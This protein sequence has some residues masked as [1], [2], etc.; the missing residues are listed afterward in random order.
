M[1]SIDVLEVVVERSGVRGSVLYYEGCY[2][3][4]KEMVESIWGKKALFS[5]KNELKGEKVLLTYNPLSSLGDK[6]PAADVII[7]DVDGDNVTVRYVYNLV[8]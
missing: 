6:A 7:A 2:D 4:V 1:K 5:I 3:S 8:D